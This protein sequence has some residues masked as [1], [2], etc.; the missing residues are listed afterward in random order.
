[1]GMSSILPLILRY[2]VSQLLVSRADSS[3][4]QELPINC[5]ILILMALNLAIIPVYEFNATEMD[6]SRFDLFFPQ[7]TCMVK[8]NVFDGGLSRLNKM[9]LRGV[10]STAGEKI[11]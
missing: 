1:M 2:M 6:D 7:I 3:S 8:V 5:Y 4:I 11:H 9:D 10:I